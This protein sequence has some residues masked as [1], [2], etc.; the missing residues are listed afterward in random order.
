MTDRGKVLQNLPVLLLA[1]CEAPVVLVQ[2]RVEIIQHRDLLVQRDTHV[3]L[4]RVQCSQ[5]QVENTNCMSASE[6]RKKGKKTWNQPKR[7]KI[8]KQV[9]PQISFVYM[10]RIPFDSYV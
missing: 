10:L 7:M 5:H 3:V 1:L 4:H 6:K 2:V 8:A 9:R